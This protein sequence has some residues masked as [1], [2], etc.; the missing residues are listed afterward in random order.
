MW[1]CN[2]GMG[3]VTTLHCR[4]YWPPGQRFMERARH[5]GTDQAFSYSAEHGVQVRASLGAG[6]WGRASPHPAFPKLT[7][8]TH[9]A[10][11]LARCSGIRAS[12]QDLILPKASSTRS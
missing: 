11:V 6:V 10:L 8:E 9:L 12:V 2:R 1:R 3:G 5:P 7:N 4:K